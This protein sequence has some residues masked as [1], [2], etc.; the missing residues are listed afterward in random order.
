[1]ITNFIVDILKKLTQQNRTYLV[2][3]INIAEWEIDH[4]E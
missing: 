2:H 4:A 3:L 1:M